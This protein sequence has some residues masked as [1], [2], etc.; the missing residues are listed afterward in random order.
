MKGTMPAMVNIA[1]GSCETSDAEGTTVC[2]RFSKNSIQRF[3]ISC[4]SI[5]AFFLRL[6]VNL[7]VVRLCEEVFAEFGIAL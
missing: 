5:E 7:G 4:E 2:P 3:E 6:V 1:P